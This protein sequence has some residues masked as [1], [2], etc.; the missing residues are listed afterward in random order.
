MA[1]VEGPD[2]VKVELVDQSDQEVLGN[3]D[4]AKVDQ[5]VGS[6]LVRM[7]QMDKYHQGRVVGQ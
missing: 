2:L 7:V 4:P 1:Q 3:Q 6:G 5:M